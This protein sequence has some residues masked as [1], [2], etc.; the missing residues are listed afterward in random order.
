MVS[1]PIFWSLRNPVR[2]DIYKILSLEEINILWV[3]RSCCH[4]LSLDSHLW[5]RITFSQ[6]AARMCRIERFVF[7]T[8]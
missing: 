2:I 8:C 6:W 3:T 7:P 1:E 5:F 4:A